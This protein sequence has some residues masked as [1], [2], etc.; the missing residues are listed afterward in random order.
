LQGIVV[1]TQVAIVFFQ[2]VIT[3][4][5]TMTLQDAV[6]YAIFL[7]KTTIDMQRFSDG[8]VMA[9]GAIAGCGGPIDVTII[10][11]NS[12]FNGFSKKNFEEKE[13][14]ESSVC[15][16]IRIFLLHKAFKH[17]SRCWC[18]GVASRRR[19]ALHA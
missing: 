1:G 9:S 15:A 13:Q 17:E 12:A 3:N 5:Q 2:V 19:P 8:I 16:C 10:Q 11:P 4:F 6:D 18:F 7:I 14:L